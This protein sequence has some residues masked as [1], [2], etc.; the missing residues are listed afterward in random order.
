MSTRSNIVFPHTDGTVSVMYWHHDGYPEGGGQTLHDHYTDTDSVWLRAEGRERFESMIAIG[1]ELGQWKLET[2]EPYGSGV[3]YEPKAYTLFKHDGSR[4][5][6]RH[7]G[8]Q[9]KDDEE[10]GRDSRTADD[11][12]SSFIPLFSRNRIA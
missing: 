2:P 12:T 7:K 5:Y 11:E 9:V 1:D 8:V 10:T 3:F 6:V 4:G